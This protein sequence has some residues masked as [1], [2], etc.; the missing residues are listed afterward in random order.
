MFYRYAGKLTNNKL[1]KRS[2][3]TDIRS[4]TDYAKFGIEENELY[5]ENHATEKLN[6][7]KP[8]R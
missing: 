8:N 3:E 4:Y 6:K 1:R 2:K 5:G 7:D